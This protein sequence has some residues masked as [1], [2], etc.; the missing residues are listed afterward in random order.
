MRRIIN[1]Y[2]KKTLT[3]AIKI[4]ETGVINEYS[5][6]NPICK[7]EFTKLLIAGKKSITHKAK[8]VR[9]SVDSCTI[10]LFLLCFGIRNIIDFVLIL[11]SRITPGFLP[12]LVVTTDCFDALND[13]A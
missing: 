5:I 13:A 9:R 6:S 11:S 3:N 1:L 4:Y 2:K 12:I 7:N 8:I 10:Q